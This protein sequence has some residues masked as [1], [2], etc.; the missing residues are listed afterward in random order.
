M[1]VRKNMFTLA[2]A[3]LAQTAVMAQSKPDSARTPKAMSWKDVSSWRSVNPGTVTLSADGK[4]AAY[5]LTTREGDGELF[6]KRVKDTAQKQYAIGNQAM[7]QFSFSEDGKWLAYKEAVSFKERR[8]ASKTPGKM[9][10]D[11]LH[12]VELSSGKKTTFEKAGNFSFNGKTSS[13]IVINMAKERSGPDAPQGSDLLIV[14]LSSGKSQN[15]GNVSEFQFNKQGDLLA[16]TIDAAGQ[17]GNGVYLYTVANRSTSVLDNDKASYKSLGWTRDGDGFTLLKMVKDEKYKTEKG[18][19]VAVKQ[20]TGTPSVTIYDPLKDSLNFPKGKTIS[21]NRKPVFA[22]AL[23]RVFFGIAP[24]ELAKKEPAKADTS[25]KAKPAKPSAEAELARLSK[26]KS[27]TS[28]KSLDDLK[29][30]IAKL[31][32]TKSPVAPATANKDDIPKPDMVIWHGSDKRLQSRQQVTGSTDKNY[33]DLAGFDLAAKKFVQY[34]DSS[35]KSITAFPKQVY[36]YAV[37]GRAYELDQ[38]LDGQN[39][40]DIYIVDLKTGAREKLFDKFYI[41]SYSSVPQGSPDGQK[42]VYGKDG[43][44]YVYDMVAKTNTN[45]TASIPT[46]FVNTEDDHNVVKPLTP[47]VDWSSDN[48]YLLIQDLWDVWQ[49]PANGKGNAINLTGNGRSQK[50]R[51][52]GRFVLDPEEKGI[53][54]KKPIY[55]R[56]YGEWTKKSGIV[57]L[58]AGKS[59]ATVLNWDDAFISGLSKAK[60]A[61]VY[62]YTKETFSTPTEFFAGDALLKDVVQITKNAP[63]LGKYAWSAG[64][65]L[66]DYVS[67]KGDTLQGTLFLPA[68]YVQGKKYPTMV[69][70]YEKLSQTRHNFSDPGFPG[71]GWHPGMYTSNGYAVFIP[72]I[73]YKMDDPGMSAVWCVL[74]AVKAAIKTG[75]IDEERMGITGHSWG[76][77]QTAFLSTQTNMFKAAA[78]GAALTNMVS[79]YDLIYWNSGGG[80]MAIFEASQGRFKGA[81]WENWDS[82]LRNSPIY[83]V[84][85]VNTPMLI[86]HNDKDGAV[87]FTQ[88]IEFYN[89]LRRLKKPVVMIQYK[90][91]NHGIAKTENRKDYAVRM[92]EFFDHHLK[93]KPAPAWLDKGIDMLKLDEELDERKF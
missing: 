75:V 74:P 36:A 10:F 60:N 73:V 42:F 34:N 93:G 8:A 22:E 17:A 57:R 59:G 14:E 26:L 11:K 61:D 12:I 7:P 35:I 58:Q 43:H 85:K 2:L 53:D 31:D 79:M 80:N 47:V 40:V 50:I 81:P 49:V 90:G 29:K 62:M 32:T 39:Y 92:M 83:H 54:L 3:L 1:R 5:A 25:G 51:Y 64:T 37:D 33:T 56:Q 45:I 27:D 4:W 91:E 82:Y 15:I 48:K 55:F 41:P 87:D 13:H 30:A 52:Q 68:G 24:L 66:V 20:F 84:K 44:Y 16:Y 72:D 77:Y 69:Y 18:A 65:Q 9:L 89:A 46:S 88:G 38:N 6:V 76:G 28:I 70:Y 19:V 23:D 78:A 21:A 86:L 67:D 71:G 63:D